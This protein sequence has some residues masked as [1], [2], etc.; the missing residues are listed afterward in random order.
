MTHSIGDLFGREREARPTRS[1]QASI[2]IAATPEVVFRALADPRE[3]VAWLGDAPVSE[4][5]AAASPSTPLAPPRGGARWLAHVRAPDGTPGT[6]SGEF[7]HVVPPRSLA[8][9]WSASWNRFVRD[10][11]TFDLAPI[12]VAGVA[13]TR[14][15][16]THRHRSDVLFRE[17]TIASA[18]A[19]ADADG[20]AWA[21]LLARLAAYVAMSSAFA[22]WGAGSGDDFSQAFGALHRRVVD[23]HQGESA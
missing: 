22:R 17:P 1:I 19:V 9:T 2:E 20:D 13:G 11:V 14:V 4:E 8:T 18:R 12:D 21:A 7:L 5:R 23:I 10:E 6:V 3:L 16:V 15:T